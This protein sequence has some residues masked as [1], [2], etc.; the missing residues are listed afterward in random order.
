MNLRDRNAAAEGYRQF[1]EKRVDRFATAWPGEPSTSSW[2]RARRT[3]AA[4]RCALDF[5]LAATATGL[6]LVVCGRIVRDVLD[7]R[8]AGA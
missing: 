8:R 5:G 2:R 7:R 4:L 3:A 6:P 1:V